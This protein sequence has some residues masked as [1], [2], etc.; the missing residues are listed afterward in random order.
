[1]YEKLTNNLEIVPHVL[2]TMAAEGH[3]QLRYYCSVILNDKIIGVIIVIITSMVVTVLITSVL[4]RILKRRDVWLIFACLLVVRL[5]GLQP[6]LLL[7]GGA[8]L[9]LG[10]Y[11]TGSS[12]LAHFS[13]CRVLFEKLSVSD[14]HESETG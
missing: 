3:G 7:C 10:R 5:R 6:K 13:A 1:M 9:Y 2:V 8:A 14:G 12:I 11:Y 4:L